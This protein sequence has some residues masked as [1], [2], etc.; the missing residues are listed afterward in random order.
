MV[1]ASFD[2]ISLSINEKELGPQIPKTEMKK[3]MPFI[4]GLKKRLIAGESKETV[5]DRT[6]PFDE[7]NLLRQLRAGLK[8][9]TGCVEVEIVAVEEGGKSGTV[10]SAEGEDGVRK[11]ELPPAA[12]AAVPG[13]PSFHF[14][15]LMP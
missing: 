11:D 9:T 1:R 10:V 6:L 4:Q 2:E 5:F 15:N 14:E 12:A 8:K 7:V 13:N 3:A